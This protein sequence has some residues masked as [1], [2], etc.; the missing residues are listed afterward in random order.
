M[1]PNL[2]IKRLELLA[3][4]RAIDN[5]IKRIMET[6][7]HLERETIVIFQSDNGGVALHRKGNC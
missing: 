6:V 3:A 7:N 5:Q 4:I 1:Y 2:G